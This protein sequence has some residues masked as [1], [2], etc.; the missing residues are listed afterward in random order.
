MKKNKKGHTIWAESELPRHLPH[1]ICRI[2]IYMV[3]FCLICYDDFVLSLYQWRESYCHYIN[4]DVP[5]WSQKLVS[6]PPFVM[7]VISSL[8]A[9]SDR[10]Q[11]L[12]V[13][14][15]LSQKPRIL[16]VCGRRRPPAQPP[17][18]KQQKKVSKVSIDLIPRFATDAYIFSFERTQM[19]RFNWDFDLINQ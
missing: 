9:D 7:T 2:T 17:C 11:A 18:L 13:I 15:W 14:I 1:H 16:V 5:W 3:I 8:Q 6:D 10:K 19:H 4:D 12:I